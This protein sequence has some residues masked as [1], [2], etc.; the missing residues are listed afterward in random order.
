MPEDKPIYSRIL[1]KLSGEA[2]MG[3]KEFGISSSM[4]D[5]MAGELKGLVELG[6]QVSVVI[7]GG[8]I[9]RGMKAAAE[10]MERSHADYIGMLATLINSLA[11]Q[12]AIERRGT[13]SRVMS[14]LDIR[15]VAEPYIRRRATRHM[16]KNRIV[17]FAAGTGN[18]F[19]TTDTAAALRAAEIRADV[20]LKATRVDGVYDSDPETNSDAVRYKKLSY[21]D[22]L[23]KKLKVMDATAISLCM[24]NSIPLIVFDVTQPGNLKKA[25]MGKSVGTAVGDHSIVKG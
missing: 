11:L 13:P 16:E 25:A 7:G 18:P 3:S 5:Y 6:I 2:L 14:A 22:V 1:V 12:D 15:H 21:M 9:F 19:F 4:M 8:N 23:N 10:G 20:I 24:E 17:I